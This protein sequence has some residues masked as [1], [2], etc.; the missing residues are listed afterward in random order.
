[1]AVLERVLELYRE[2][3]FDLNLRHFHEKLASEHRVRSE[4]TTCCQWMQSAS[5]IENCASVHMPFPC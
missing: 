2:K 3:Y 5:L 1:V 4:K